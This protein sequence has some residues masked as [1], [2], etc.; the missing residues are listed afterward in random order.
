MESDNAASASYGASGSGYDNDAWAKLAHSS[1]YDSRY[2]KSYDFVNAKSY[3]NEEYARKVR[4]DDDQWAEDFD[5]QRW[6]GADSWGAA[7]SQNTYQPAQSKTVYH[8]PSYNG[9]Y[10]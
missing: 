7:S 10:W 9:Y 5:K 8:Q 2:G 1:D 3:D 6:G 4:A